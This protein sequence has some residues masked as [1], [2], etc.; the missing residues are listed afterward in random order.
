VSPLASLL[1]LPLLAVFQAE[2]A[3]ELAAGL[4]RKLRSI[5]QGA[6]PPAEPVRISEA[7][8]NAYIEQAREELGLPPGVT[9]V[10]IT[11][12][13]GGLLARARIELARLEGVPE[14]MAGI[15]EGARLLAGS[16]VPVEVEGRFRASSG[17]GKL[18]L[19]RVS[20]ASMSVPIERVVELVASSTRSRR[21]PHGFDLRTPFRLPH[22]IERVELRSGAALLSF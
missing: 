1:L 14:S 20:V 12:K 11:F 9:E 16:G 2:P 10:A 21:Y 5:V 19:E 3:S 17:F 7:E 18:D 22:A 6:A 8:L 15:V 4:E 13:P